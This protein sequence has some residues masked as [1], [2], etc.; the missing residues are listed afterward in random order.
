MANKTTTKKNNKKK[1]LNVCAWLSTAGEE[2]AEENNVCD[3]RV[4]RLRT[5]IRTVMKP[6]N[7]LSNLREDC[8]Q[9][10]KRRHTKR[11]NAIAAVSKSELTGGVWRR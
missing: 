9:N 6:R 4:G 11:K 10:V 7:I 5:E 2:V 1:K 8:A 3:F